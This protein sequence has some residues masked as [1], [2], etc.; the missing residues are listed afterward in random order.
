MTV[1]RVFKTTS[2]HLA[3]YLL[4]RGLDLL[5]IEPAEERPGMYAF[6]FRDREDRP[7]T[8]NAFLTGKGGLV[9]VHQFLEAQRRL[10]NL[11]HEPL[12]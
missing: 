8:V 1:D 5:G 2:L 9:D 12:P 10:R 6:V 7:E 11:V 4:A 3:A